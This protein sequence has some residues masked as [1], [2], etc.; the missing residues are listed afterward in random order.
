MSPNISLI[1]LTILSFLSSAS[2]LANPSTSIST[3]TPYSATPTSINATP[4]ASSNHHR[5]HF[6]KSNPRDTVLEDESST[7]W[8]RKLRRDQRR[9]TSHLHTPIDLLTFHSAKPVSNSATR[10][11]GLVPRAKD[12]FSEAP[13]GNATAVEDTKIGNDGVVGED[14]VDMKWYDAQ[15]VSIATWALWLWIIAS[16]LG[17]L[18]LWGRG[19]IDGFG[20][21]VTIGGVERWVRGV[22]V[23]WGS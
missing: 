21:W 20:E 6:Q 23:G 1:I 18:A 10:R 2:I 15:W 3:S 7:F 11:N 16:V 22:R 13:A 4:T 17:L 19:L 14:G 8:R 9:T 12:D 5:R